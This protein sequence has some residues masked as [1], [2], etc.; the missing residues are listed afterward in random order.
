[1]P[2]T[3]RE[4]GGEHSS[5]LVGEHVRQPW[6]RWKA[7]LWCLQFSLFTFSLEILAFGQ[8]ST[9]PPIPSLVAEEK[10][11]TTSATRGGLK[12]FSPRLPELTLWEENGARGCVH[13]P[14]GAPSRGVATG[15]PPEDGGGVFTGEARSDERSGGARGPRFGAPRLAARGAVLCG[16]SRQGKRHGSPRRRRTDRFF[17]CPGR[18]RQRRVGRALRSLVCAWLVFRIR[19]PP[20]PPRCP[21]LHPDIF[22]HHPSTRSK[23]YRS[24]FS[25]SQC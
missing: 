10:R 5:A 16:G 6:R 15:F 20:P 7:H 12:M 9:S 11:L 24:A 23:C 22:H 19:P 3:G 18:Q 1:M 13:L 17:L 4:A 14:L 21:P 2:R 25:F 8:K